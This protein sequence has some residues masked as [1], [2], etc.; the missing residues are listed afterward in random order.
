MSRRGMVMKANKVLKRI[1]KIE[2]LISKVTDR[3]SAPDIRELLRD[4]KAAVTRAKDA[5]Q[6]S[7]EAA[8]NHPVGHSKRTPEATPEPSKPQRK[9]SA[10]G[11]KAIV[12]ATKRRWAAFHAAKQAEKPEP[13]LPKKARPKT[14]V[15]KKTAVKAPPAKTTVKK[16]AT[17]VAAQKTAPQNSAP[18]KTAKAPVMKAA[19]KSVPVT[20][21]PTAAAES[22]STPEI[23]AQ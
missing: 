2:A 16:T 5:L 19:K 3:S 14:T 9:L 12:T 10:A 21:Q 17:K 15:R 4:A 20:A 22:T 7:S 1:A 13:A 6:A 23:V 18:P 11:R 8:K